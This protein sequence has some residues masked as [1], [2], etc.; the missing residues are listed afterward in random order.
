MK[1][2]DLIKLITDKL[3]YGK[4]AEAARSNVRPKF[5]TDIAEV[6]AEAVLKEIEYFMIPMPDR[7]EAVTGGLVYCY[8]D[9]DK[10]GDLDRLDA[11]KED[12]S[13]DVKNSQLWEPEDEE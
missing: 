9:R 5:I 12:G 13:L 8:Y 4:L 3:F 11:N 2:S 10:N 6:D 1:R 7:T